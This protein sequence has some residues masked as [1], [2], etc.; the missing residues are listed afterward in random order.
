MLIHAD[1]H[2]FHKK[3]VSLI[4]YFYL[5]LMMINYF[6][7]SRYLEPVLIMALVISVAD[8]KNKWLMSVVCTV[9]TRQECAP[10]DLLL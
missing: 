6:Q 5:I 10:Q 7:K 9:S 2:L 4:H 8:L 1:M 3:N